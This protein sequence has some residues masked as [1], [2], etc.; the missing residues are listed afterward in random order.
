MDTA[1]FDSTSEAARKG[2]GVAAFI[3]I[4]G[5]SSVIQA[6]QSLE[7]LWEEMRLMRQL[8][9]GVLAHGVD[10]EDPSKVGLIFVGDAF[11]AYAF[12]PSDK[13][14]E[15]FLRSVCGFCGA[16]LHRGW[17]VRAGIAEDDLLV[18]E[19][20]T[21]YLGRAVVKAHKLEGAQ[22]WFG[23]VIDPAF[24]SWLEGTPQGRQLLD[25]NVV[26]RHP[27]PVKPQDEPSDL[28]LGWPRGLS[29]SRSELETN[30]TRLY[31]SPSS[32]RDVQKIRRR[33]E[34][35]LEFYELQTSV[36]GV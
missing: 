15:D 20:R 11:L 18:S 36:S 31:P 4:S 35:M 27:V 17:R 21:Y 2:P 25:E 26:V 34:R 12:D 5:F 14:R 3:D 24:S 30:L 8:A 22:T 6:Q 28:A 9:G 13:V 1:D 10:H 32:S 29:L 33:L 16:M 23:G 19:D 7:A